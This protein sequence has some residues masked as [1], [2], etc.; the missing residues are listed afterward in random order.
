[1]VSVNCLNLKMRA[2]MRND[3][4]NKYEMLREDSGH[5]IERISSLAQIVSAAGRS[6]DAQT[7]VNVEAIGIVGEVIED[8]VIRLNSVLE[9]YAA[10]FASQ[11][12]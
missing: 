11:S 6:P 9:E 4:Q 10:R 1:M 12:D 7:E 8:Y 2:A 5:L 3:T